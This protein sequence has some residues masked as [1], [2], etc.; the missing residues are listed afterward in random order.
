LPSAALARLRTAAEVEAPAAVGMVPT[1]GKVPNGTVTFIVK[2]QWKLDNGQAELRFF[3]RGIGTVNVPTPRMRQVVSAIGGKTGVNHAVG[4]NLIGSFHAPSLVVADPVVLGT[5]PRREFRAGLY[6]VIKCGV[7]AEPALLDRIR[8][9]QPAIFAREASA[10]EPL[11]AASCRIKAQVVTADEREGGLR[12]TLNFGHTVGHALEAATKYKRFRHGE[13][14]GYGMLAALSL[15]VA[16][17]VTP[18]A[19]YD[20]VLDL[21]THLGPL[22][23]V[24]DISAKEVLAGS[25]NFTPSGFIGQTNVVHIV[26]DASVAQALTELARKAARQPDAERVLTMAVRVAH[27]A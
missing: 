20:E 16:R 11:V 26:R 15:G 13:A 17:G 4:K 18:P 7:I 3:F 23:P 27:M 10:V 12:R 14:I 19:L 8:T 5:L 22:P 9:T 25:A 6:E 24:S 21:V 1:V 2:S